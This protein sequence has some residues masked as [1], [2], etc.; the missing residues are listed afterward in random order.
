[1][2][3]SPET[4]VSR[5]DRE[6]PITVETRGASAG[7]SARRGG[8]VV[9]RAGDPGERAGVRR[10]R[11]VERLRRP[12]A[13]GLRGHRVALVDAPPIA[14]SVE[15]GEGDPLAAL[16]GLVRRFGLADPGRGTGS[17][18][19]AVPGGA[20][21]I[22]RLRPGPAAGATAAPVAA[23]LAAARHPDG[24]VRHGDRPTT[25]DRDGVQLLAWDLT[26]EGLEA[27][28]RRCRRWMARRSSASR[29][30]RAPHRREPGR[31]LRRSAR[32]TATT[33][34]GRRSRRVLEY[35]A[36]GDV[37]QVNLSQRFTTRGAFDPLELY[38]RLRD[39]SPAPFAA[40]LRWGDLAVVSASP[41]WFYQT[42]GDRIV[43]RPIKGTRPRG[44]S[45]RGRRAA[46]RRAGRVGE[47]PRRADH[48]RGPRTQRPGPRLPVWLGR[49]Q[50]CAAGRIVRPGAPPR[51]HGRGAAA[52]RCRAG[53]RRPRGV[54]GRLDHRAPKIRAME[55][56]DELEPN[57]RSLYTGAIGYLS[58]GG[59]SGF[60]IAIRTILVEGD[61]A[62][63]QVGGGIVAD[64]D[65]ESEYEETLAKGRGL[66]A[67]LEEQGEPSSHDLD[68]GRDRPRR[69]PAHQRPRPDVRAWAGALRDLSHLGR[70]SDA[71][72]RHLRTDATLGAGA[73]ADRSSRPTCRTTTAVAPAHRL[74]RPTAGPRT[75]SGCGSSCPAAGSG[76]R[77]EDRRVWMTA[78]P[79]PPP[80]PA[81]GARIVRS[82]LA[83]P[84]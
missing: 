5:D 9:G 64:S 51:R 76:R 56:I 70:P 30:S 33:Y 16:A 3:K 13:A 58:R 29:A 80:T 14:G 7:R 63:Y 81:G 12:S 72:A 24:A 38:L 50:G 6:R 41:E 57:R 53:R 59:A 11:P 21:R 61:R 82:I 36:A 79:L 22:R 65:P 66:R 67:V 32:S 77:T 28:A 20:D 37:F 39:R 31:R 44:R 40:F 4:G 15:A 18:S 34:C 84:R 35:I 26:G 27:A 75:T 43:T 68:P 71:A 45:P 8:R 19:A 48:D 54:P 69:G 1:M 78:G 25:P 55:I 49:R 10:R 52:A 42:R 73:R 74:R 83:D 46:R 2:R 17:R 47:G 62:S 23:R 60:N